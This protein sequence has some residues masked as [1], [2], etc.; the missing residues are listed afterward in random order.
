MTI[1]VLVFGAQ[2]EAAGARALSVETPDGCSCRELLDAVG[3]AHPDLPGLGVTRVAINAAFA[4]EH[5][6]IREGDEV[7]LI[8]MVGGG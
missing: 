5:A 4:P 7:A 8:A 6:V 2:A 1:R 3:R